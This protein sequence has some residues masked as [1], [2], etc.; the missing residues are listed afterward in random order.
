MS[1]SKATRNWQGIVTEAICVIEHEPSNT[2]RVA[3]AR[4]LLS[5]LGAMGDYWLAQEQA[6]DVRPTEASAILCLHDVLDADPDE[7]FA[8]PMS[9][10]DVAEYRRDSRQEFAGG[11]TI[12]YVLV[13]H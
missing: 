13:N 9:E 2:K 3:W 12:T 4:G 10:A 11:D 5:T 8:H 1:K 6:G 7:C